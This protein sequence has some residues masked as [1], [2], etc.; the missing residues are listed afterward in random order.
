MISHIRIFLLLSSG[1]SFNLFW[2]LFSS[3]WFLHLRDVHAYPLIFSLHSFL[4]ENLHIT[5]GQRIAI[6]IAIYRWPSISR[7]FR[8]IVVYLL[9]IEGK[10]G[11]Y[12]DVVVL[13]KAWSA[14]LLLMLCCK[15]FKKTQ[16]V[17]PQS[18][19][20]KLLSAQAKLS[21]VQQTLLQV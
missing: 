20:M 16:K 15:C 6:Y 7:V 13:V 1:A 3:G 9:Y 18:A 14:I 19:M 5:L 11:Q 17:P 21:S 10:S 8:H 4:C 12:I 2:A